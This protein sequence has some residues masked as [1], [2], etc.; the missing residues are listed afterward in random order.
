[1]IGCNHQKNSSNRQVIKL[2]T[3]LMFE[4]LLPFLHRFIPP[5]FRQNPSKLTRAENLTSAALIA[6]IA[7]PLYGL[8]Y[9]AL[10]DG[11]NA[12]ACLVAIIGVLAALALL[13]L[14]ENLA[15]A[16]E[17][18][19]AVLFSLL[20]V[21]TF[22]LGGINAPTVIWLAVCPLVATAAGGSRPGIVWSILI[23]LT[24]ATIYAMDTLGLFPPVAVSDMRLLGAVS[25]VSFV[26]FVGVFLLLFERTN[27][28][29]VL[30]LDQALGIIQDLAIKDELTGVFNRRELIRVAEQEKNRVAQQGTEFCLCLIDVDYFKKINDTYGHAAGDQVLKRIA[31]A[32]QETIRKT[33]CFGRY[34]G[35]EF[36]LLLVE[37]DAR[38]ARSFADRIRENIEKMHFPEMP[39]EQGVTISIGVAQYRHHEA[40]EHAISRADMALYEAKHA[41]RNRVVAADDES[42]LPQPPRTL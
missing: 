29:A 40:I 11:T 17:T 5:S 22:R 41:G 19:I 31:L 20:L 10:G 39:E 35:E 28:S 23:L 26:A 16:R 21:L 2:F 9:H 1:V 33:D 36:L 8:L 42:R 6:L 38:A 25:T 14:S 4:R 32:I 34:G 12:R 37:A 27:A 13:R 30:K 18:L 15:L 3:S 7:L 24:V